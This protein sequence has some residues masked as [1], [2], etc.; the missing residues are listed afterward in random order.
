[1]RKFKTFQAAV[2]EV[3]SDREEV[4]HEIIWYIE[5]RLTLQQWSDLDSAMVEAFE[6]VGIDMDGVIGIAGPIPF[7]DDDEQAALEADAELEAEL[8]RDGGAE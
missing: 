4:N 2:D 5:K 7:D 6:K 3:T 1:M 8:K